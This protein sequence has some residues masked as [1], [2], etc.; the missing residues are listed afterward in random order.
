MTYEIRAPLS[1]LHNTEGMPKASPHSLSDVWRVPSP[2]RL[3]GKPLRA[4]SYGLARCRFGIFDPYV[5][6]NEKMR[7]NTVLF[8]IILVMTEIS[9]QFLFAR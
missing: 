4:R 6:S 8:F 2:N 7:E 9:R 5:I 1:G 3:S